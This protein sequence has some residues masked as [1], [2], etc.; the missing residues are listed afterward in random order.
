ML[1]SNLKSDT[2][3]KFLIIAQSRKSNFFRLQNDQNNFAQSKYDIRIFHYRIITWILQT[4]HEK[5]L[6]PN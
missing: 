6:I 2:Q 3:R 1:N 4:Y 5:N